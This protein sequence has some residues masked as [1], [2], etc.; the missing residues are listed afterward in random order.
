MLLKQCEKRKKQKPF[1]EKK[2]NHLSW[3][4]KGITDTFTLFPNEKFETLI[5]KVNER[6]DRSWV[7]TGESIQG[8]ITQFEQQEC[9]RKISQVENT[10]EDH[11]EKPLQETML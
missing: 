2:H 10:D 3:F 8:A 5:M 4:L 7:R 9:N 1:N 11:V 6:M